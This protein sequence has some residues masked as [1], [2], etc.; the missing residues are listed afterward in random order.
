MRKH[1]AGK[2]PKAPKG[3]VRDLAPRNA[4]QIRGGALISDVMK[5]F[6]RALQTAARG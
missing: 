2:A 3:R 4:A 1:H 6:G 5:N